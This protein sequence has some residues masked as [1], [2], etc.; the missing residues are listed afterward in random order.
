MFGISKFLLR[1]LASVSKMLLYKRKAVLLVI[2][3]GHISKSLRKIKSASC[4]LVLVSFD[5][6]ELTGSHEK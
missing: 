2:N 4:D 6:C 3:E 1:S 5:V